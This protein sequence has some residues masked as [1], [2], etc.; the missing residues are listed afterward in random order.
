MLQSMGSQRVR[1]DLATEL[2]MLY[3]YIFHYPLDITI[4]GSNRYLDLTCPNL[5]LI[6]SIS[7]ALQN[8]S[9]NGFPIS[10]N[11]NSQE[12]GSKLFKIFNII[13]C[14]LF[15]PHACFYVCVHKCRHRFRY[16]DGSFFKIY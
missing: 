5:T 10:I 8:M 12:H 11:G 7:Y 3:T 6:F 15:L 14:S 4:W 16:I 13:D 9:S 1:H 2:I